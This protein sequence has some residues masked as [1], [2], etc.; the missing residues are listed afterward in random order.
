MR[1]TGTADL[2]DDEDRPRLKEKASPKGPSG[3][4]LEGRYVKDARRALSFE[5]PHN[6][7]SQTVALILNSL[8]NLS[9]AYR[10]ATQ[11]PMELAGSGAG[12]PFYHRAGKPEA[13]LTSFGHG[14]HKD[15]TTNKSLALI[16]KTCTR[17]EVTKNQ[18]IPYRGKGYENQRVNHEQV[19]T[20]SMRIR[21]AFVVCIR[22][23]E[24]T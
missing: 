17:V 3:G 16:N 15:S 14:D 12:V 5:I 18:N 2:Y 6:P 23:G 4:S 19:P 8:R 22:P 24:I 20:Y 7:N 11:V 21:T 10:L 1:K 13:H 9:S